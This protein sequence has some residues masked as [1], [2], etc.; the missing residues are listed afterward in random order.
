MG[1]KRV[2]KKLVPALQDIDAAIMVVNAS[3]PQFATLSIM[4]SAIDHLSFFSIL[5]KCDMVARGRIRQLVEK[6]P[7]E[8][9]SASMLDG[10]GLSEIRYR[11]SNWRSD[12]HVAILGVFNSGKTSLINA[13]TGE[14]NKVGDI[15]GTTLELT[16]HK[17]NGQT[18]IDTVGQIT[19]ISKPLMVS[20]DLTGCRSIASKL[21]RCID[22]DMKAIEASRLG[23]LEP[24]KKA[25]DII[26]KRVNDGGKVLF[27]GAGA[28]GL[29]AMSMA[30]QGQETG[31]PVMVF[32]N[33]FGTAQPISF[34][35]GAFEDELALADYFARAVSDKDVVVGV[36]A[37]GGTGFV[38]KFLEMAKAKGAYDIAITENRDTPLGKVADLVIKSESKPEGPS[39]SRV[40]IS[41]LAIGHA[42]IL[43]IA[44]VRG[45]D[46]ETAIRYMLPD[47]CENKKMGIK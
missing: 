20:V 44:D 7:G 45:V 24:L 2:S 29:V 34:A 19:D 27:C 38:F 17:Y 36:S 15:P 21:R 6:I 8:V 32:T 39:S 47:L 22:E 13:L 5:N 30:G 41:H 3:D 12:S 14:S 28:S 4:Y 26:I 42:L 25:V 43:T 18:L 31:L 35:K 16:S 46:A 23:V 33:N 9:I 11:L 40:M 10:R 37:S 1:L